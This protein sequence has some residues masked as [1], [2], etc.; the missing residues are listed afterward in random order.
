MNHINLFV[1]LEELPENKK[2]LFVNI[3]SDRALRVL[4]NNNSLEKNSL[5]KFFENIVDL[6]WNNLI[7]NKLIINWDGQ[8]DKL[9]T[10]IDDYENKELPYKFSIY[11]LSDLIISSWSIKLIDKDF[12]YKLSNIFLRDMTEK[13]QV[14]ELE[15][16]DEI[17]KMICGIKNNFN[18]AVKEI[19]MELKD[20]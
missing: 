13:K 7:D 11:E 20:L 14:F 3:M 15:V 5:L 9:S 2:Y 19:R 10:L 16:Q 4:K 6:S 18:V 12:F 1:E 17:F 8:L